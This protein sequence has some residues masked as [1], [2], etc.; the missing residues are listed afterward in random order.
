MSVSRQSWK[1]CF[2]I[3]LTLIKLL[4]DQT[5]IHAFCYLATGMTHRPFMMDAAADSRITVEFNYTEQ[6]R[7]DWLPRFHTCTKGVLLPI[8]AYAANM[9]FFSKR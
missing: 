9:I 7:E 5:F 2:A 4:S 6:V 1:P 3:R 8:N